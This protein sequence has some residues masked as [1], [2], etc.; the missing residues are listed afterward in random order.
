MSGPHHKTRAHFD[1][2][3]PAPAVKKALPDVPDSDR[4][5]M[6]FGRMTQAEIYEGLKARH[7]GDVPVRHI[8][9]FMADRRESGTT[10]SSRVCLARI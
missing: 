4:L 8:L 10:S 7:G 5:A 9:A 2:K 1:R 6:I 3:K